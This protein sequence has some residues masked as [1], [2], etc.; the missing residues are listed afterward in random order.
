MN[1]WSEAP[2]LITWMGETLLGLLVYQWSRPEG[3]CPG[4][5]LVGTETSW[6]NPNGNILSNTAL[7]NLWRQFLCWE[8]GWPGSFHLR[9]SRFASPSTC[10]S[11]SSWI[12]V[13]H[14]SRKLSHLSSCAEVARDAL[15]SWSRY[16]HSRYKLHT[17]SF[18]CLGRP[19]SS[20]TELNKSLIRSLLSFTIKSLWAK[21]EILLH[22]NSS[23]LR[24]FEKKVL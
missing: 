4:Q 17:R 18:F 2:W 10:I 20:Y 13:S 15:E 1:L 22:F 14:W 16:C 3:S 12:A 23:L 5:N 19:T 11:L 9:K 21:T 7:D 6:T 8:P 24:V